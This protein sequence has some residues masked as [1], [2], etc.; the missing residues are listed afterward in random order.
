M[1]TSDRLCVAAGSGFV[2]FGVVLAYVVAHSGG[3]TVEDLLKYPSDTLTAYVAGVG[4]ALIGW[5]ITGL[6]RHRGT[7]PR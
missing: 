1:K 2:A 7:D 6:G 3:A 4:A 5:G